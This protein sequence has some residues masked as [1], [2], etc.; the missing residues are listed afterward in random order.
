MLDECPTIELTNG[1]QSSIRDPKQ[2]FLTE[3]PTEWGAYGFVHM[4]TLDVLCVVFFRESRLVVL[5]YSGKVPAR[6]LAIV[7]R[8]SRMVFVC[9][10]LFKA[11][12]KFSNEFL[13]QLCQMAFVVSQLRID[14]P[15]AI[16][17][18]IVFLP[19]LLNLV[20]EAD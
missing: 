19:S 10:R 20:P 8:A 6:E 1:R 18:E 9:H 13:E 3:E 16:G 11:F 2:S 14:L 15:D 5:L 17:T 12:R 4:L 7:E